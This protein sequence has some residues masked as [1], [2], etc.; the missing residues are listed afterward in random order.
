MW[1][2]PP[3]PLIGK[4]VKMEQKPDEVKA[5][6]TFPEEMPKGVWP[7]ID[8]A[9]TGKPACC[10]CWVWQFHRQ[11][12]VYVSITCNECGEKRVLIRRMEDKYAEDCTDDCPFKTFRYT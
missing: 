2:C 10:G 11:G 12:K 4:D 6:K 3:P 5:T 8:H 9:S 7:I 1:A